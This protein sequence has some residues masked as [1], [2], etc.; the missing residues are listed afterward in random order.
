METTKRVLGAEHP[1][2]LT[3]MINFAHTWKSQGQHQVTLTLSEDCVLLRRRVL[4]P[5]HPF[6]LSSLAVLNQWKMG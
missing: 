2:T 4:S 6:T 1:D 5:D 3:S